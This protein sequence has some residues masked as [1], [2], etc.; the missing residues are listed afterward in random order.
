LR[1]PC[2]HLSALPVLLGAPLLLGAT[3]APEVGGDSPAVVSVVQQE[4]LGSTRHFR[5]T[6]PK[7]LLDRTRPLSDRVDA[8]LAA[9]RPWLGLP[10]P[11]EGDLIWVRDHEDLQELLDFH[12]PDWFAAVTQPHRQRIIMVVGKAAGQEQLYQTLRHELVHWTMQSLGPQAWGTL[13]AWFHEG[14]A[15]TWAANLNKPSIQVSLAWTAF[16]EEL[17]WLA[18]YAEGFGD[19]PYRASMGYALAEAFMR[20]LIRVEGEEV[21]AALMGELRRGRNLDQALLELT[22]LPLVDHE[23]ALRQELG[24][25]RALLAEIAPQ[26]FTILILVALVVLPLA[27]RRRRLRHEAM[28]ARWEAEDLAA[29]EAEQPEGDDTDDRWLHLK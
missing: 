18:E 8:E 28:V 14:V 11:P 22:G 1:R 26:T 6:S 23:M 3:F 4:A 2:L 19:N 29:L 10:D 27:M 17:P 7:D 12:A 21:V 20:R 9:I 15:E 16:H 5:W 13:P 25:L 24:S